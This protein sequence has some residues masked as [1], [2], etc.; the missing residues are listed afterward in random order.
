MLRGLGFRG[1]GLVCI[2][3][4]EQS[5]SPTPPGRNKRAWEWGWGLGD[6]RQVGCLN[7]KGSM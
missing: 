3:T 6:R 4:R 7:P 2:E 1:L 5:D